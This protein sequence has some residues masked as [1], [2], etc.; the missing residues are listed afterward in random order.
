M[1]EGI[2]KKLSILLAA[3]VLL[4]GIYVPAKAQERGDG[5]TVTTQEEF[6]AALAR[7]EKLIT[8]S[9]LITI[10]KEAESS[11]RLLPVV[12]PAGTVV[13]GTGEGSILNCRSPIQLGGD[14]VAFR[15]MKLT[16]ESSKALGSVPHREIFLAGH[17]LTMDNVYTYLKGPSGEFGDLGDGEK[18]LLP[19]IYAGGYP[20]TAVGDS[21]S[22]TVQNS[23]RETMFQAIYMGHGAVDG[24]VPYQGTASLDLDAKA[25]VREAVDTSLNSKAEVRVSGSSDIAYAKAEQFTGN[26]NTT[27][28]VSNCTVDHADVRG[29]GNLVIENGGQL[30][31]INETLENV[32][33]KNG[34]CLN[35][36]EIANHVQIKGNFS[37]VSSPDEEKGILVLNKA[38]FVEIQGT[39]AGTTVFCASDR[40]A[41]GGIYA[42]KSYISANPSTKQESFVLHPKHVENGFELE[43]ENGVWKTAGNIFDTRHVKGV[44]VKHAPREVNLYEI[45]GSGDY[46]NM[47]IPNENV[48]FELVWYD[49]EENEFS[50][51]EA[52]ELMLYEADYVVGIKTE[53]WKTDR[54]DILGNRDWWN[55]VGL[56]AGEGGIP[57]RYY[58][59]AGE[60]A[61][62]GD[63]TFLFLSEY[64]EGELDTVADVKA[65]KDKVIAEKQVVFWDSSL[66]ETKPDLPEEPTPTPTVTPVPTPTGTPKPTATPKPTPTGMPTPTPTVTPVP[67]PTGTPKPTGTPAP[68]GTPK[69]TATPVPTPTGTPTPSPTA[70]PKP[71][72]TPGATGTPSQPP[73]TTPGATGTPSQPPAATP[74]PG[75]AGT[76]VTPPSSQEPPSSHTHQYVQVLQP[77]TFQADGVKMKKCSC[78]KILEQQAIYQLKKAEL[79]QSKMVYTGSSRKPAVKVTD[80][81]GRTIGSQN[82]QLIYQ[83]NIYVGKATAVIVFKGDYKG[84][85]KKSFTIEP[86]KTSLSKLKAKKKGFTISWKK[87]SSQTSGYELQ[88]ST[89]SKFTKKATKTIN[90]KNNRTTTK[91]ISKLKAKKKYYARIRTYK[92][93]KVSGKTTKIYSGWSKA[94]SVKT[95]K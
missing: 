21:A 43:Y 4:C 3:A 80:R 27:L 26:S 23:N 36:N 54:T 25:I 49:E 68:T 22:L 53:Y 46:D 90:I 44:S 69:P 6:M 74:A 87:Q 32:T 84:S 57:G 70:T 77:A 38:G 24:D 65:L 63:Y 71:T 33:L 56:M 42:G 72:G 51:E 60:G 34:G 29:I 19:T 18:E 11:G 31:V 10:G 13:Q 62:S 59:Y 17:S 41:L 14:G 89:S 81:L 91:T 75:G 67:T 12:F 35:L 16:M 52:E 86:G 8:I 83:N 5:V 20:G 9:G 82:Y 1:G 55:T 78:G 50:A 30:K 66:G 58:L 47:V 15:N 61:A 40:G 64:F 92:N 39:V 73:A 88:Y 93:V 48:Y 45:R 94:K 95:K 76:P 85:Q 79:T 37:G 28:T 2:K 7:N